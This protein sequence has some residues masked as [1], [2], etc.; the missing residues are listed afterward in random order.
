MGLR[1]I[2][3]ADFLSKPA[4]KVRAWPNLRFKIAFVHCGKAN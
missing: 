4:Q 2:H 1:K 3:Q